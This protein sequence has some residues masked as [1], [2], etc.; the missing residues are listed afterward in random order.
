MG[1]RAAQIRA[2]WFVKCATVVLQARVP[3]SSR[4]CASQDRQ[5]RWVRPVP[6]RVPEMPFPKISSLFQKTSSR[7]SKRKKALF[8]LVSL[9]VPVNREP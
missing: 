8:K 6:A 7:I 5:N 4:T 3:S 1:E 2:E 9:R